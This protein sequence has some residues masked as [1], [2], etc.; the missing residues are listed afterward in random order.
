MSKVF[1]TISNVAIT[2]ALAVLFHRGHSEDA[3]KM[4]KMC[5]LDQTR[6]FCEEC[7]TADR[8]DIV[9]IC[10]KEFRFCMS[11]DCSPTINIK[12]VDWLI[13]HDELRKTLFVNIAKSE[14]NDKYDHIR[15]NLLMGAVELLN[16]H[17]I[18]EL[19]MGTSDTLKNVVAF[20]ACIKISQGL[21]SEAN[22]VKLTKKPFATSDTMRRAIAYRHIPESKFVFKK[23]LSCPKF[24]P[25]DPLVL[26]A[27]EDLGGTY[28]A[29]FRHPNIDPSLV[30]RMASEPPRKKLKVKT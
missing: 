21:L 8:F 3:I 18:S 7:I 15:I 27:C 12:L 17:F 14:R 24:D 13:K 29:I 10:I 1:H 22:Y 20:W 25:N 28:L 6:S 30:T 2:E 23:I 5:S 9:A 11:R 16:N 19:F 26:K 4:L